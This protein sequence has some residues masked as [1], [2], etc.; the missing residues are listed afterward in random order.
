MTRLTIDL[1]DSLHKT[2]KS[3]S[4]MSGKT[5][6]DMAITAIDKYAKVKIEKQNISYS[7]DILEDE[8]DLILKPVIEEY[9]KQ[10][11][12]NQF[13]GHDWEDVKKDIE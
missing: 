8:A 11:E 9:A 5:M 7:D 1:P 13:E 3:L 2:L 12:S 6:R 4:V 10:I